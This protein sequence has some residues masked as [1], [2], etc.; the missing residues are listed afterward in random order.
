[1]LLHPKTNGHAPRESLFVA[2]ELEGREEILHALRPVERRLYLASLLVVPWVAAQRR[3]QVGAECELSGL[4]RPSHH[5]LDVRIDAPFLVDEK[6]CGTR[7]LTAPWTDDR[8]EPNETGPFLSPNG[9]DF[10][11]TAVIS[12]PTNGSLPS[13]DTNAAPHG[14]GRF[15]LGPII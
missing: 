7:T 13:I 2:Q 3:E 15:G 12:D 9:S 8:E 4:G 1:L 14:K 6:H 11:G 5:V 10:S